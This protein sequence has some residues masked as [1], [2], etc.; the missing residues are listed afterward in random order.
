MKVVVVV[1]CACG[2]CFSPLEWRAREFV[3]SGQQVTVME[4]KG[5]TES[6][7]CFCGGAGWGRA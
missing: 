1:K 7:R 2:S 3:L 4:T 6:D 5:R